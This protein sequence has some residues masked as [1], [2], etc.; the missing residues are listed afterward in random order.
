M[1]SMKSFAVSFPVIVFLHGTK[2]AIFENRSTTTQMLSKV[3]DG[4][5]STMKSIETK[6]HVRLGMGNGC[7]S[8]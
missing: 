6:D 4:G 7:N 5:R 1:L 3:F 8:P 2:W